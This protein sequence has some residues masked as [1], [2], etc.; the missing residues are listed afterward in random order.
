MATRF[1]TSD[2]ILASIVSEL[3]ILGSAVASTTGAAGVSNPLLIAISA[4][5]GA[6]LLYVFTH[7][8][9]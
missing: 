5:V 3:K 1:N 4:G 6:V 9:F 8:K 2:S 7:I